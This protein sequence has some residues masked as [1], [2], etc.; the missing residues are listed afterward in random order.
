MEADFYGKIRCVYSANSDIVKKIDP[1]QIYLFGSTASGT[2]NKDS[3][4]DLIVIL[5]T[6][7]VPQ[8]FEEKLKDKVKVR[9]AIIDLSM[10]VAIDLLVYSKG[11]FRKL[12]KINKPFADEII[13]KGRL[14]YERTRE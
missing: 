3:D 14:L 7:V 5:N 6:D 13:K 8:N 12:Q 2:A 1:Y 4:I 11:E 10:E 9:N